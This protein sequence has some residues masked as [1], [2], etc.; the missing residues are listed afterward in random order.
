M[1]EVLLAAAAL[2]VTAKVGEA[3]ASKVGVSPLIAHVAAGLL[4]GPV[5]GLVHPSE[6]LAL[7]GVLGLALLFFIIGADEMDVSGVARALRGRIVVVAAAALVPPFA[8]GLWASWYM[9]LDTQVGIVLAGILALSSLGVVAKVLTDAG[10]LK[11]P[12]GLYV[13]TA[14]AVTEFVALLL[15]SAALH[16]E[17]TEDGFGVRDAGILVGQIAAFAVG[18][19][20]LASYV[21]PWVLLRLRHWVNVPEFALAVVVAALLAAFVVSEEAG[22]HGSLGALLFGIALSGLPRAMRADILPPVRSLGTGLFIPLFFATSGLRVDLSFVD[23]PLAFIAAIVVAAIAGKGVGAALAGLASPRGIR[24]A[25]GAGMTGKGVAELALLL[26]LVESG[27][28]DGGL[29]SLLTIIMLAFIFV[30]PLFITWAMKRQ[31]AGTTVE[32]AVPPS[33]ARYALEGLTAADAM[34]DEG[35]FPTESLSIQAF[36]DAW[37]SPSQ[38]DYAV[39]T[40]DGSLAGVLSAS[41]L[42]GVPRD[43]WGEVTIGTLLRPRFPIASPDVS[44]D[45][46]LESMAVHGLSIVPVVDPESRKVLGE[47]TN[48]DVIALLASPAAAAEH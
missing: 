4:W 27:V 46:V 24:L 16:A 19:W 5:L 41:R 33:Y 22:L 18:A 14:V 3:L 43:S 30:T 38:N 29:F 10:Q 6:G 28:I 12:A 2:I 37:L 35:S 48:H 47:I 34:S 25:T 9:G 45:E 39:V 17:N 7:L 26:V 1:E 42:N 23:M 20:V 31:A 32:Q 40:E 36:A 11:R 15:V 13:F 21:M 8:A 44:L